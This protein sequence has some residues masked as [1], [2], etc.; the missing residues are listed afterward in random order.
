M[1]Y[2][3]DVVLNLFSDNKDSKAVLQYSYLNPSYVDL[4]HTIVP[5]EFRGH[6]V[7]KKLAQVIHID[8]HTC[9]ARAN[10]VDPDQPAHRCHLIRICTVHF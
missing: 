5:P 10:N 3:P 9:I 8:R 4:E 7:A 1:I 6:G 2:D